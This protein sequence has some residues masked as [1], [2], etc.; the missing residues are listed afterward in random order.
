MSTREFKGPEADAQ[1]RRALQVFCPVITLLLAEAECATRR[2]AAI[3]AALTRTLVDM[4]A[5]QAHAVKVPYGDE[6]Q[7]ALGLAIERVVIA[8]LERVQAIADAKVKDN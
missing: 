3:Q 4:V 1:V 7:K 5:L 6:E 2:L 8:E